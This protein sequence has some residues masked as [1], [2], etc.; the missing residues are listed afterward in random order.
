MEQL[1]I[2]LE[3]IDTSGATWAVVNAYLTAT[4]TSGDSDFVSPSYNSHV[5]HVVRSLRCAGSR[6]VE[7]IVQTVRHCFRRICCIRRGCVPSHHITSHH[8]T[9]HHI[10]SHYIASHR[11]TYFLLEVARD[12]LN[13]SSDPISDAEKQQQEEKEVKAAKRKRWLKLGVAGLIGGAIIGLST[14][15]P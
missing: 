14:C 2:G 9:S 8:I 4:L 5:H 1:S 6:C 3:A 12:M 7:A 15:L 13:V 10:T 11:I